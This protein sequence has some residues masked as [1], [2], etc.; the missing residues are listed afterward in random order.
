[1]NRC[2]AVLRG[3]VVRIGAAVSAA[4]FLPA[5]AF[6]QS[7]PTD[8]FDAA[9]TSITTKVGAYSASLVGLAAVSVGFIVA[10]KYVK[11][12]PRAA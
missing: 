2:F 12:L 3:R 9:L 11:R 4:V 10:I 5:M 7:T 8:P 6:A 1:M